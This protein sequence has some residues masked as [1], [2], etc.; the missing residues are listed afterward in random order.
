V[1]FR[2]RTLSFLPLGHQRLLSA[3]KWL[4]S[5]S[6]EIKLLPGTVT[7][8]DNLASAMQNSKSGTESVVMLMI[9]TGC[10]YWNVCVLVKE[11]EVFCFA[12][13]IT[14][15]RSTIRAAVFNDLK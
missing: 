1:P 15:G 5:P 6:R 3:A 8:S 14:Q 7:D 13:L 10:C 12:A 11:F 2:K 4:G 9:V